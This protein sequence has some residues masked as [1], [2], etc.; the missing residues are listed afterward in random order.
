LGIDFDAETQGR[1]LN[2]KTNNYQWGADLDYLINDRMSVKG[3][4]IIEKFKDP[5]SIAGGDSTH[6]LFGLEFTHSF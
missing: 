3:R 6:H 5:D 2:V 1:R 4:Y